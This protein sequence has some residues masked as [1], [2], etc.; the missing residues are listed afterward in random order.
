MDMNMD[1][2]M[3]M[4]TDMDMDMDNSMMYYNMAIILYKDTIPNYKNNY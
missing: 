4:D 2:N 1:I 3:D